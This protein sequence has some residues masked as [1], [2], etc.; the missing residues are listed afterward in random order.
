MLCTSRSSLFGAAGTSLYRNQHRRHCKAVAAETKGELGAELIVEAVAATMPK[1]VTT[2]PSPKRLHLHA[3]A[4]PL[5]GWANYVAAE[6]P[7]A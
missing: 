2:T 6:G 1:T 4:H 5:L 7:N 3:H